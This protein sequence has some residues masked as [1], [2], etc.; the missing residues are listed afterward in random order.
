MMIGALIGELVTLLELYVQ[1]LLA[2]G[3]FNAF[4]IFIIALC[5]I[6]SCAFA[7]LSSSLFRNATNTKRLRLIQIIAKPPFVIWIIVV[8]II[9]VQLANGLFM[10]YLSNKK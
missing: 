9:L 8:V 3:S 2:P 6:V 1:T 7:Y 10:V 5:G 4:A